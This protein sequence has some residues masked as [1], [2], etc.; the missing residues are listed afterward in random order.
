ME[1]AEILVHELA[2]EI[3]VYASAGRDVIFLARRGPEPLTATSG[4]PSV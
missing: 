2:A 1:Q 3:G 4:Y